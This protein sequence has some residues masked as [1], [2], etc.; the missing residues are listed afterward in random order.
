MQL[1]DFDKEK[2]WLFTLV[3]CN[4][5]EEMVLDFTILFL[6]KGQNDNGKY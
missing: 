2:C 5:E 4:E 3:L 6:Q 1:K